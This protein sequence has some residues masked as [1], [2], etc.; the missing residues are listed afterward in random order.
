[1]KR[2][3]LT[4]LFAFAVCGVQAQWSLRTY[5]EYDY[6][7]TSGSTGSLAVFGDCQLRD[8]FRM[9][10]G[11]KASLTQPYAF[12]M[13]WQSDVYE[14]KKG[15]LYI[16]NRY[17]YRLFPKYKLQEF[18]AALDLG[19]RTRHFNFHLGLFSR[20]TAEIPLR[21]NGGMGTI[22]EPMNIYYSVEGNI[23]A[24]SHPWNIGARVSN[25]DDFVIERVTLFR[26]YL[27]GY[28]RLNENLKL[29]GEVCLHPSGTLNLSSQYNGLS[30]RVGIVWNPKKETK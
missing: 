29:T 5:A 16:E 15:T 12:N 23:F 20:Y 10:F 9:S 4:I 26:Y 14:G 3:V 8:S 27:I 17:L 25:Y 22:F 1:M 19:Y 21:V 18:S 7:R 24:Q 28:Y 2:K 11:L 13:M 30:A 6:T